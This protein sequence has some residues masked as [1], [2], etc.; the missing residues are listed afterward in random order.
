MSLFSLKK[1]SETIN[2]TLAF[3]VRKA[4]RGA[5]HKIIGFLNIC[6]DVSVSRTF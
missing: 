3:K 5:D 1:K 4:T 6:V 2:F